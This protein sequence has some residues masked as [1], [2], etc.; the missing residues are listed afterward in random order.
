MCAHSGKSNQCPK[1]GGVFGLVFLG[2]V[3]ALGNALGAA[4]LREET[5]L[6]WDYCF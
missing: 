5:G 2:R 4:G 6:R 1:M 3:E